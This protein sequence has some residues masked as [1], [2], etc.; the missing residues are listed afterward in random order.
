MI[1]KGPQ[2][3]NHCVELFY[4]KKNMLVFNMLRKHHTEFVK[5]SY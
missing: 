2:V 1:L 5:Q 4:F 3:E